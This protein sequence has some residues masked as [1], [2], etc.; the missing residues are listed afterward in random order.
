MDAVEELEE[1]GRDGGLGSDGG[2]DI[3]VGMARSMS[4]RTLALVIPAVEELIMTLAGICARTLLAFSAFGLAEASKNAASDV[5]SLKEDEGE[6]EGDLFY[7]FDEQFPS[8]PRVHL[9]AQQCS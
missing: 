2:G 8:R 3:A 9:Q 7:S 5:L 6:A 1:K 4:Q